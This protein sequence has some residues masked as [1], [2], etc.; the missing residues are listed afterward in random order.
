MGLIIDIVLSIFIM[1]GIGTAVFYLIKNIHDKKKSVPVF[2]LSYSGEYTQK[3]F[4]TYEIVIIVIITQ[5]FGFL[6]LSLPVNV[7]M[8][9]LILIL[10]L[11]YFTQILRGAVGMNGIVS[12]KH[13]YEWQQVDSVEWITGLQ[14]D[15]PGYPNWGLPYG[16]PLC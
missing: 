9:S 11:L 6:K 7:M 1:T 3:N 10:I 15:N 13:F 14:A 16:K 4:W 2:G 12:A 5:G 8:L